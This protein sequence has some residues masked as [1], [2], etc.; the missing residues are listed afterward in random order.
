[1]AFG[2]GNVSD[3]DDES[4]QFATFGMCVDELIEVLAAIKISANGLEEI[5]K[6]NTELS[7]KD[8]AL[9]LVAVENH[10]DLYD[11]LSLGGTIPNKE[12][13]RC[14]RKMYMKVNLLAQLDF[15]RGNILLNAQ[16][17]KKPVIT[18]TEDPDV[19]VKGI[20]GD[21]GC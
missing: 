2:V 6:T 20:Y 7:Q 21:E 4:G 18:H 15:L 13:M 17:T 10:K 3:D 1:L 9:I 16:K 8:T 19:I 11:M 12:V 5:L 14:V